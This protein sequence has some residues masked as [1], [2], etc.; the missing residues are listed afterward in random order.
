MRLRACDANGLRKGMPRMDQQDDAQ[1]RAGREAFRRI[2]P[3]IL[4]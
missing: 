3:G 1:Q 4:S 2:A